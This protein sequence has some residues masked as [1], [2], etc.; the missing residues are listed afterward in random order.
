MA[1]ITIKSKRFNK[2]KFND[3]VNT[4]FTQLSNIPDPSYFDKDLATQEDF[5]FLY[6]KMFYIIPKFFRHDELMDIYDPNDN[7]TYLAQTS[8]EYSDFNEVNIEVQALLDEIAEIRKENLQLTKESVN[9]D[10]AITIVDPATLKG[11]KNQ[12]IG[13]STIDNSTTYG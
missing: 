5:F 8:A 2:D 11:V 13:T 6:E 10:T 7:H 3:T 9:L 4:N 1:N 12:N